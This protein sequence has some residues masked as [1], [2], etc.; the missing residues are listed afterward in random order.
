MFNRIR[1]IRGRMMADKK[2]KLKTLNDIGKDPRFCSKLPMVARAELRNELKK[3]LGIKRI[4]ALREEYKRE[5]KAGV[6]LPIKGK[7][8]IL[9]EIFNIEEE[10]LRRS[11]RGTMMANENEIK[12]QYLKERMFRKAKGFAINKSLGFTEDYE[13]IYFEGE[14]LEESIAGNYRKTEYWIYEPYDQQVF[15]DIDE[16]LDYAE[17]MSGVSFEEYKKAKNVQQC[18]LLYAWEFD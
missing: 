6:F 11:R 4:K 2:E 9:K 18:L 7:V 14:T 16:A 1:I 15:E 5:K 12:E 10:E 8:Q 3:E 13:E 17:D